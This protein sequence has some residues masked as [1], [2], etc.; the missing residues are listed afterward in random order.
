MPTAPATD[1]INFAHSTLVG[2]IHFEELESLGRLQLDSGYGLRAS[3]ALGALLLLT[4]ITTGLVS[5]APPR[6][7]AAG[8]R[9]SCGSLSPAHS[10]HV[11]RS[12]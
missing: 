7:S 5:N 1:G 4:A 2:Q 11:Y 10:R 8:A 3:R 9:S 12:P 6:R